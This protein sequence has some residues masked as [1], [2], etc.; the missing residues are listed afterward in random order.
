MSV[1][2]SP[3]LGFPAGTNPVHLAPMARAGRPPKNPIA[4]FPNRVRELREEQGLSQR[5]LGERVG[6][7]GAAIQ[8]YETGDRQLDLRRAKVIA[9]ALDV[10]VA[11]LLAPAVAR[12]DDEARLLNL[13]RQMGARA[14][15]MLLNLAQDLSED[16]RD[17]RVS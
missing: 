3:S 8:R 17:R 12:T 7:T 2:I 15:G 16:Y 4:V 9:R 13:F 10:H 6:L 1:A 5:A 11:E 14:R